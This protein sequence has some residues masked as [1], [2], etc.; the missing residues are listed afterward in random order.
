MTQYISEK[1]DED[2]GENQVVSFFGGVNK[3]RI[4]QLVHKTQNLRISKRK[5]YEIT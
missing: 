3:K 1:S 2:F 5:K 4:K